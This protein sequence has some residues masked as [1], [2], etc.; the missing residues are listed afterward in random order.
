VN[1]VL[2]I[3]ASVLCHAAF[4][5]V[6]VA[7]SLQALTDGGSPFVIGVLMALMAVLPMMLGVASGR[8]TD[9]VGARRPLLVGGSLVFL[10][11]LLPAVFPV[12]PVLFLTAA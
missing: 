8:W 3:A 9:R 7:V 10:G 4:T 2:I 6:R 1:L 5:G 11:A 12:L